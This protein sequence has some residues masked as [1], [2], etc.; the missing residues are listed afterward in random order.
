MFGGTWFIAFVLRIF[1]MQ[2]HMHIDNFNDKHFIFTQQLG[3][4]ATVTHHWFEDWFPL[5]MTLTYDEVGCV[6]PVPDHYRDA[7]RCQMGASSPL[8]PFPSHLF[9]SLSLSFSLWESLV[10]GHWDSVF[11]MKC[12]KEESDGYLTIKSS[13]CSMYALRAVI[14][15][16]VLWTRNICFIAY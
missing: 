6:R 1:S 15:V 3:S 8:L 7:R 2:L 9:L 16:Y 11:L 4:G 5:W 13:T 10:S 12:W 14:C